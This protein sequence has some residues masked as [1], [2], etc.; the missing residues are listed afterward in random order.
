M[1]RR[2]MESTDVSGRTATI[3]IYEL[4]GPGLKITYTPSAGTL[5]LSTGEPLG[6]WDSLSTV[7]FAW[8]TSGGV[9]TGQFSGDGIVTT[10][11]VA[12]GNEIGT[13]VT[14]VLSSS[15]RVGR[16]TDLTLLLPNPSDATQASH[17]AT[18]VAILTII[19]AGDV[20]RE[21][22]VGQR[23]EVRALEGTVSFADG[24][25]APAGS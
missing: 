19:T 21:S 8:P 12:A 17:Q 18:G 5:E 11:F 1:R 22:A 20:L 7:A 10:S 15:D 2:N 9:A 14:V 25:P 4:S 6:A 23:Y 16:R 3:A 13:L 24:S